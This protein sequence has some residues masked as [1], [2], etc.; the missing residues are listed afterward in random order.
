MSFPSFAYDNSTKYR[1]E[2]RLVSRVWRKRRRKKSKG[3]EQKAK[4]KKVEDER[5]DTW[6]VMRV[7]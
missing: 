2:G 4:V 7:A 6:Y 5:R 1:T 3:K